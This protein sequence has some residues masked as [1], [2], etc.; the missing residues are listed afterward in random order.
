MLRKRVAVWALCA[1]A[2]GRSRSRNE[3]AL[4]FFGALRRFPALTSGGV[5]VEGS[6][7]GIKTKIPNLSA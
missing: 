6:G 2:W 7:N 5:Q 1:V 3:L 4:L